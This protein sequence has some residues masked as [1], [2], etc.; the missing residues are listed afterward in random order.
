MTEYTAILG[1][2][3][4]FLDGHKGG[5]RVIWRGVTVLLGGVEVILGR[6]KGYKTSIEEALGFV[7]AFTVGEDTPSV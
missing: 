5:V 3:N 2:H 1:L 4:H 6:A 7:G